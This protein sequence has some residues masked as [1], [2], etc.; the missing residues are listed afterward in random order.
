MKIKNLMMGM[1]LALSLTVMSAG[2]TGCGMINQ[3]ADRYEELGAEDEACARAWADIDAQL[4]R[5]S[6]MIPNLVAV[7]KA[8]AD[9]ERLTMVQTIEQR[10]AQQRE[11]RC[12]QKDLDDAEKM[13]ACQQAGNMLGASV[14]HLAV[15][16]ERYPDLKANGQFKDLMV[17]IEG[18]ENRILRAREQYNKAVGGYNTKLRTI[19]SKLVNP[20]TGNEFKPRKY[21]EVD[22]ESRKSP[23]VDFGP[24]TPATR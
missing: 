16:S 10:A 2:M 19:K 3:A 14:R 23:K 15:M 22:E 4:Q 7:V 20:L 13:K 8:G 24:T 18:T 9:H 17:T 11:T 1:G 5:R 21:F 12:T 6:D